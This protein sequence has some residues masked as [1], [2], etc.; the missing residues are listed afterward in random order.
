MRKRSSGTEI[1][2]LLRTFEIEGGGHD[3]SIY[4]PNRLGWKW[5]GALLYEALDYRR[6]PRRGMEIGTR[7]L[8]F[9]ELADLDD[10]FRPFIPPAHTFSVTAIALFPAL[11]K[12]S[13]HGS[14]SPSSPGQL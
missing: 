4:W 12:G 10:A 13:A 5:P 9:L 1:G 11:A 8:L 6:L 3:F 7:I 14:A 2:H